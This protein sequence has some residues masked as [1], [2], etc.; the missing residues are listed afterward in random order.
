MVLLPDP[1]QNPDV[2]ADLQSTV[3]IGGIDIV[4]AGDDAD[5]CGELATGS[6]NV[7]IN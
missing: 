1:G 7:N 6:D 2:P 5:I 3:K 4:I